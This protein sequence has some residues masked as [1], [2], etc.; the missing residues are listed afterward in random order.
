MPLISGLAS[1]L[2]SHNL[3]K[4]KCKWPV[5]MRLGMACRVGHCNRRTTERNLDYRANA[6]HP[7]QHLI[8]LDFNIY[9]LQ[10][11]GRICVARGFQEIGC[12]CAT[13]QG[14]APDRPPPLAEAL[15]SL[16]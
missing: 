3:I 15:V 10:P 5:K 14:L 6:A 8:G 7:R 4:E 2:D 13:G 9:R 11:D 16:P 12:M 1:A